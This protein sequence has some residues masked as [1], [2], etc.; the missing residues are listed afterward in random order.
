MG[1]EPTSSAWKAEV[2][3]LNY[4]RRACRSQVATVAS[5][6]RRNDPRL[7]ATLAFWWRGKDSNL[8]RH[9]PADL[10]SAPVGR[11]GTPPR[12]ESRVFSGAGAAVSMQTVGRGWTGQRARGHQAAA[13]QGL[14]VFRPNPGK[15]TR[16]RAED[17]EHRLTHERL[18]RFVGR[19]RQT[20]PSHGGTR[21]TSSHGAAGANPVAA[22]PTNDGT[23]HAAS[24][25]R[26]QSDR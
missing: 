20:A 14:R 12:T 24:H 23:A 7:S 21:A 4:T 18:T 2:L 25:R 3:P 8:R 17:P 1:I 5:R 26:L 15:P 9:K 10:Q 11:L 13:R 6:P 22:G 19:T 16:V